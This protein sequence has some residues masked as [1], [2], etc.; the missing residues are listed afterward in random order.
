MFSKATM[1][2][3]SYCSTFVTLLGWESEKNFDKKSNKSKISVKSST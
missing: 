1:L 2:T 3:K